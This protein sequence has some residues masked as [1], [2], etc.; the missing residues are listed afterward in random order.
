MGWPLRILQPVPDDGQLNG[1]VIVMAVLEML[2][3]NAAVGKSRAKSANSITRLMLTPFAR[4]FVGHPNE[5]QTVRTLL[6]CG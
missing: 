4:R 3:A 1:M 6:A 5:V 2:F